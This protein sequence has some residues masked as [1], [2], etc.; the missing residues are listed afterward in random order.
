MSDRSSPKFKCEPSGSEDCLTFSFKTSHHQWTWSRVRE[1]LDDGKKPTWVKRSCLLSASSKVHIIKSIKPFAQDP[2][3][4][5]GGGTCTWKIT[6]HSH[7]WLKSLLKPL[8]QKLFLSPHPTLK[9]I[10]R[11]SSVCIHVPFVAST[12][13]TFMHFRPSSALEAVQL[14]VLLQ[15]LKN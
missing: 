9:Q 14:F 7:H 15:H 3:G 10:Y 12:N 13:G 2:R 11:Q 1:I 6:G 4:G 8:M 5:G